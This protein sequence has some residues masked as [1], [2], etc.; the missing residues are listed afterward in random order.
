MSSFTIDPDNNITAL[1]EVPPPPTDLP[2]FLAAVPFSPPLNLPIR[3]PRSRPLSAGLANTR[4]ER[5]W[6]QLGMSVR[7]AGFK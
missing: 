6:R 4:C 1:V 3:S 7:T 5:K 2:P